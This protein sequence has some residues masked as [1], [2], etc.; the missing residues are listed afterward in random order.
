MPM[1]DMTLRLHTQPKRET[2]P[3]PCLDLAGTQG[4]WLNVE[5]KL[6]SDAWHGNWEEN[7]PR[8]RKILFT[9]RPARQEWS[10]IFILYSI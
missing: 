5:K 1:R 2:P 9:G 6:S 10:V 3:P 8:I 4:G 7:E